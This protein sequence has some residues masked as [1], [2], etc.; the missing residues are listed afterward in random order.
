MKV[1]SIYS[2]TGRIK[3]IFVFETRQYV[4]TGET[5]DMLAE[6]ILADYGNLAED[7]NALHP[8]HPIELFLFFRINPHGVQHAAWQDKARHI[9]FIPVNF[10]NNE[11]SVTRAWAQDVI[12]TM[13]ENELYYDSNMDQGLVDLLHLYSG[14]PVM[15]PFTSVCEGGNMLRGS[16]NGFD[17][18]I[19]T[20]LNTK[21]KTTTCTEGDITK[22][23]GVDEWGII[24]VAKTHNPDT[25]SRVVFHADMYS[26]VVGDIGG[27]RELILV[28]RPYKENHWEFINKAMAG[29]KKRLRKLKYYQGAPEFV[30]HSIPMVVINDNNDNVDND[31]K[32][33]IGHVFSYNNCLVE[34]YVEDGT[35]IINFYF[36]D[37][38]YELRKY[39]SS[40]EE[41]PTQL[42]NA[43]QP[44]SVVEESLS[45]KTMAKVMGMPPHELPAVNEE[46][47]GCVESELKAKLHSIFKDIPNLEY[48]IKF[49]RHNF[50]SLSQKRGGLHCIAKV[51]EREIM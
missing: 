51:I 18:I 21:L 26:T 8:E 29:F 17:Y 47:I 45:S 15:K 5:E 28:A 35:R 25:K 41:K 14:K 33:K 49:V 19:K 38:R 16:H 36:P 2:A 46:F 39:A 43:F 32:P 40:T 30:F 10:G 9:W 50:R 27:G 1:N 23:T 7:L 37:F 12:G 3:T 4:L 31:E 44:G 11:I 24:N 22:M 42:L 48:N 6:P 13:N 20:W 34:N